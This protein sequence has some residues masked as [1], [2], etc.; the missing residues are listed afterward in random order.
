LA[1]PPIPNLYS[2]ESSSLRL[3]LPFRVSPIF[4]RGSVPRLLTCS[5]APPLPRFFPLQRL[6]NFAEPRSSDSSQTAGRVAS[7]GFRTL[8]TPCSP[9]SLPGLFHPGPAHG[10]SLRGFV[11]QAAPY[12]LRMSFGL[13]CRVPQGFVLTMPLQAASDRRRATRFP[14]RDS[15]RYP[16]LRPQVLGISQ[17]TPRWSLHGFVPLQGFL[18]SMTRQL[19]YR[20]TDVCSSLSSR[21]VVGT[22]GLTAAGPSRALPGW[23]HCH[24]PAGTPGFFQHHRERSPSLSRWA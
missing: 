23:C 11:P 18:L 14:S 6:N 5:S 24:L 3:R 2:W 20:P 8:S 15:S 12:T 7:S 21:R 17:G 1:P 19:V 16:K 13:V 10:V 9:Q 4:H 22:A